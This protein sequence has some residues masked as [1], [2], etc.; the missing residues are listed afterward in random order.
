MTDLNFVH[1]NFSN[2]SILELCKNLLTDLTVEVQIPP[3]WLTACFPKIFYSLKYIK[4]YER[5]KSVSSANCK[6]CVVVVKAARVSSSAQ[7]GR[8]WRTPVEKRRVVWLINDSATG[9]ST[10]ATRNVCQWAWRGRL[11]R[12]VTN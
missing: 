4:R 5:A 8:T 3:F 10:V 9:V 7:W 11:C 12:S 1:P 6:S 2:A